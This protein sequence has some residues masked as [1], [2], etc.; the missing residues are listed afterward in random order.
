M[1]EMM[2]VETAWLVLGVEGGRGI[3]SM[4]ARMR[5]SASEV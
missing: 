5:R 4:I 1:R 2:P 3:C